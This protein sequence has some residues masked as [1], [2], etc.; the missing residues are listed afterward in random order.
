[1]KLR[2][3]VS[4]QYQTNQKSGQ[5]IKT[6]NNFILEGS[7]D[8]HDLIEKTIRGIAVYGCPV[9]NSEGTHVWYMPNQIW[10]VV[11]IENDKDA[12]KIIHGDI[13]L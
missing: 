5:G 8:S 3:Y 2:V 6:W 10:K 12:K 11:I 7:W 1:M 4:S 9:T 13:R